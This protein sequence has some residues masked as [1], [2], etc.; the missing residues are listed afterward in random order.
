MQNQILPNTRLGDINDPNFKEQ[1]KKADA[2][3][4]NFKKENDILSKQTTAI[5]RPQ[6]FEILENLKS[7]ISAFESQL[8]TLQF[9]VDICQRKTNQLSGD[10]V[11]VEYLKEKSKPFPMDYYKNVFGELESRL[12]EL[13]DLV[14][15][16]G[17][18]NGDPQLIIP[19][20]KHMFASLEWLE[21]SYKGLHEHVQNISTEYERIKL[22]Y[23]VMDASGLRIQEYANTL[24]P[25]KSSFQNIPSNNNSMQTSFGL[26]KSNFSGFG[27]TST[28]LNQQN[29]NSFGTTTGF[30]LNNSQQPVST[31]FGGFTNSNSFGQTQPTSFGFGKK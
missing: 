20:I 18:E 2:D 29:G 31:S 11:A 26:P 30:N 5:K 13:Q 10:I 17:S 16:F 24:T 28:A 1:I 19:S 12:K 8:S 3:I 7:Q 6:Y 27:G 4:Q 23:N 15:Q 21:Q 25:A 9:N 22:Q 14:E